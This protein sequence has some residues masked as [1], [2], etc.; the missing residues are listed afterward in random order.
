MR[1][2]LGGSHRTAVVLEA[3]IS[4]AR[5]PRKPELTNLSQSLNVPRRAPTPCKN[6]ATS[7]TIPLATYP[8][9]TPIPS[10]IVVADVRNLTDDEIEEFADRFIAAMRARSAEVARRER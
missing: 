9:P 10:P 6:R 3:V 4:T 7:C 1:Q 5:S 8:T 2:A